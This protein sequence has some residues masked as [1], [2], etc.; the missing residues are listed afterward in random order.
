M[1]SRF[2]KGQP[3]SWRRPRLYAPSTLASGQDYPL[4]AGELSYLIKVLRLREGDEVYLFDGR[5]K[6]FCGRL[7]RSGRKW[8]CALGRAVDFPCADPL[9]QVH[10]GQGSATRGRGDW[11]VEKMTELGAASITALQSF[12]TARHD[13]IFDQRQR[14]QRLSAAAAAQCGRRTVPQIGA[15]ASLEQ[16][17]EK[18]PKQCLRLLLSLAPDATKLSAAAAKI[19][20]TDTVALVVGRTSGL[21][22]QEEAACKNAGFQAVSMGA[23]VLRVESAGAAALAVLFA[24][25]G[26]M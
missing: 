8:L 23:R 5:G 15:C 14:W 17:C 6:E 12:G 24:A 26:E 9:L 1:K 22:E 11:A 7:Q 19:G 18:L 16:W 20:S 10:V 13:R 4:A 2:G 21:D 25:A 3:D